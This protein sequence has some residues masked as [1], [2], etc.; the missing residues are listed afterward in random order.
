MAYN[1]L[2]D[3]LNKLGDGPIIWKLQNVISHQGPL[4]KNHP[5]YM[6]L[7]YNVGV[8]WESGEI[9]EEYFFI[10]TADAPVACAMYIKQLNPLNKPGWKR[11]KHIL[12]S[13][14]VYS[15]KL[16]KQRSYITNTGL[17]S[18][19]EFEFLGIIMKL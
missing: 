10:I 2:K 6:E 13:S 5:K 18:S 3:H 17:N 1:E 11:F 15:V 19:M 4:D 12:N 8:K 16:I 14:I 7:P 9:T